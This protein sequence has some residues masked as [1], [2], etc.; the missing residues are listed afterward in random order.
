M[1]WQRY[2]AVGRLARD[3]SLGYTAAGRPK[4]EALLELEQPSG[5][6]TLG[7]VIV[8]WDLLAEGFK[9]FGKKRAR[10][11]VEGKIETR[12]WTPTKNKKATIVK[13]WVVADRIEL[14][15]AHEP[16]GPPAPRQ[17]ELPLKVGA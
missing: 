13:Q 1:S 6:G 8:A 17:S 3:V 7:L 2:Q 10:I 16:D 12:D 4:A 5:T 9:V 14:K 11:Y 15:A